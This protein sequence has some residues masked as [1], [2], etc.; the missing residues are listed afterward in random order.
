MIIIKFCSGL[1]NQLYQY[2]IYRQMQILYPEQEIR[3]DISVFEDVDIL[4]RGNGFD[5]GFAVDKF[6]DVELQYAR[7]SEIYNICYEFRPSKWLRSF[8]PKT[9]L[10]KI[11]GDSR[12]AAL[13]AK[14]IPRLQENKN[15]Y[16][17][18][19]PANAYNGS[20]FMLDNSQ[21]YYLSGLWQ[22]INYFKDISDILRE[23]LKYKKPLSGAAKEFSL[24]IKATN[25]VCIHMRRGDFTNS[26]YNDSHNICGQEYY[27]EAIKIIEKKIDDP[28]Y[29]IFSDD[30][31]FCRRIFRNLNKA[32]FVSGSK[33]IDTQE[34][35]HLMSICKNAII[36]NSTFAF[37]AV[38]L[39]DNENKTV[40]CPLYASKSR[41]SW[42]ELSRPAH[43]IPI[44]NL[45]HR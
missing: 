20:I 26:T 33:E 3:A 37:W 16:I 27:E 18:A 21:D 24:E 10:A 4:N 36:S 43:W 19:I 40:V 8:M 45:G 35:M 31:E 28:E 25:S 17:T 39:S 7:D 42:H 15:K 14:F 44:D 29:Y 9:I 11:A 13:R 32:Y 41:N 12:F 5:Y 38:W 6:F 22:N 30:I 23:E 2:A 34:E 1:G